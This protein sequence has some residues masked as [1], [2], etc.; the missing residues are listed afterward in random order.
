MV[1]LNPIPLYL[2]DTGAPRALTPALPGGQIRDERQQGTQPPPPIINVEEQQRLEIR[3]SLLS[4]QQDSSGLPN[5][6]KHALAA[7]RATQTK[8]E[9]DY[10]SK[11]L[12]VDEYA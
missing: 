1:N 11:V 7:Y 10:V 4:R 6:S 8:D 2:P 12:G 9:R 3:A 5:R